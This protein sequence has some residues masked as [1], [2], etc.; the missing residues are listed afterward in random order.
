MHIIVGGVIEKDGKYLLVQEAKEKCYGKWNLPA[1]HLDTNETPIDGAKREIREECGCE[2]K[3]T[4]ICQIGNQKSKGDNLVSIIFTTKLIS[5]EIKFD[6]NEI[7]NVGWFSYKEIMNMRSELRSERLI[8]G[9]IDN[10]R[11]GIV[12]PMEIVELGI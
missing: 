7:L 8:V 6:K 12:A 10:I 2:V 1:G 5:G 9:T 11:N 3:I 4:G